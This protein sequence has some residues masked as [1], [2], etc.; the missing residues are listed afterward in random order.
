MSDL[1]EQAKKAS[2]KYNKVEIVEEPPKG[3]TMTIDAAQKMD[4][5]PSKTDDPTETPNGLISK[6]AAAKTMNESFVETS[7]EIFDFFMKN[8]K[9]P[10]RYFM[11]DGVRVYKYGE[12]EAIEKDEA[13]IV[14]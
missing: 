4:D 6:V 11:M 8:Q 14:P 1:I 9:H 2:Q 7:K 5:P 10:S 13:K 12:R 3:R